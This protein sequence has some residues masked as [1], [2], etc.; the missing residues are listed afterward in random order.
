M[1]WGVKGDSGQR[2]LVSDEYLKSD[3]WSFLQIGTRIEK[4]ERVRL[5]QMSEWAIAR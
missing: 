4:C 5:G 2:R 1:S 3:R